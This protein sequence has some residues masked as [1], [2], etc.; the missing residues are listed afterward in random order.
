MSYLKD[1]GDKFHQLKEEKDELESQLK[2]INT[3][4]ASI[5]RSMLDEMAQEGML[6]VELQGK[7]TFGTFKRTF[8]QIENKEVFKN[9]LVEQ[10][11]TDLLSVNHQTLNAYAKE[12]KNRYGDEYL[13]P[14]LKQTSQTKLRFS[15]SRS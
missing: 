7:G 9:Y 15:K 1:L 2:E 13:V 3:E 6:R 11:A 14:G 8:F 4:L 5:E 10:E 12:C